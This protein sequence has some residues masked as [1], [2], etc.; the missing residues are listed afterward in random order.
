MKQNGVKQTTASTLDWQEER[1][2]LFDIALWQRALTHLMTPQG[3]LHH[4]L[5][6]WLVAPHRQWL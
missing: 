1:P 6:R 3:V 2:T 5:G 4:T